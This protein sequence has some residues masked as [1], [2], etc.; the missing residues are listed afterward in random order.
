MHAL[1]GR[2]ATQNPAQ[3]AAQTHRTRSPAPRQVVAEDEREKRTQRHDEPCAAARG[4]AL[5]A[6]AGIPHQ[7]AHAGEQVIDKRADQAH[8]DQFEDAEREDRTRV[9]IG[10]RAGGERDE[11]VH[12]QQQPQ[13][14]RQAR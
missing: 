2:T 12:Q 1:L 10:A 4:C 14:Q 5:Q 7:V 9:R 13:R 11:P 8:V 3:G 6:N